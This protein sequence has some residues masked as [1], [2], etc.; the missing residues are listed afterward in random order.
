MDLEGLVLWTFRAL[1]VFLSILESGR[2][3]V[4]IDYGLTLRR[5]EVFPM[6]GA[7]IH[8]RITWTFSPLAPQVPGVTP[9][10]PFVATLASPP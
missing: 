10:S 5:W 8:T 2:S 9:G 1:E 4:P 7:L 3:K 6:H